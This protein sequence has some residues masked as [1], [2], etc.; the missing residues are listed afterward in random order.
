V[1]VKDIVD[2]TTIFFKIARNPKN[3]RQSNPKISEF[4][5]FKVSNKRFWLRFCLLFIEENVFKEM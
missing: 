4:S 1:V 2:Q 5:V 3:Y